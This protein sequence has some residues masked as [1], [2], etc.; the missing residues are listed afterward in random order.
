MSDRN[1]FWMQAS[2]LREELIRKVWMKF[3]QKLRKCDNRKYKRWP[4]PAVFVDGPEPLSAR[5]NYTTSGISHTSFETS[6]QWTRRRYDNEKMAMVWRT[7]DAGQQS[8]AQ[9]ESIFV[10][11]CMFY[12]FKLL[13]QF[14]TGRGQPVF[15]LSQIAP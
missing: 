9:S 12:T 13:P 3:L 14:K 10:F 5:L 15:F 1:R 6:D 2:R 8:T 11:S 7:R 4:P